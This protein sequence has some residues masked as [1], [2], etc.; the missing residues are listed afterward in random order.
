MAIVQII[1]SICA[2]LF[3]Y[4]K[5]SCQYTAGLG[6]QSALVHCPAEN[7]QLSIMAETWECKIAKYPI[8]QAYD[9]RL[10]IETVGPTN[11]TFRYS[12]PGHYR[13]RVLQGLLSCL[14]VL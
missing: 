8:L 5:Y 6:L 1:K 3:I 4:F 7:R 13:R 14:Q 11:L 2:L 10:I 9:H 12:T